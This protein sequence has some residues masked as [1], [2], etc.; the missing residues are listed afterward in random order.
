MAPEPWSCLCILHTHRPSHSRGERGCL[1]PHSPS[2]GSQSARNR[3]QKLPCLL[4]AS[5]ASHVA[6][7][8][9]PCW[10]T[11]LAVWFL[12]FSPRNPHLPTSQVTS[13]AE[14]KAPQSLHIC[15]LL[16]PPLLF[17]DR[18][19][20]RLCGSQSHR[21]KLPKSPLGGGL[22]DLPPCPFPPRS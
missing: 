22:R 11:I 18:K 21:E 7:Q 4:S 6:L 10:W 12:Q 9:A 2:T 20:S 17:P 8:G 15:L 5:C 19:C 1:E 14:E 13:E 16:P 3:P